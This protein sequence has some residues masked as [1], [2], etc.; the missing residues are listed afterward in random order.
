MVVY[1]PELT[2]NDP[3]APQPDQIQVGLK[4]HQR[5]ALAKAMAMERDGMIRYNMRHDD[6]QIDNH[7]RF[8]P[9]RGEVDIATNV[10]I[11]G[12]I[13]G[14]GKTLTALGIIASTPSQDIFQQ[15]TKTLSC[16]G[17]NIAH[18]T[19]SYRRPE[20]NPAD[21]FI[22]TTLV[23]VP[24]GPVYVQW[25][26]TIRT[27]TTLRVLALDSLP[28]I[29]KYC[30]G[31]ATEIADLKAFFEQ[32]DVVLLTNTSIK[33][34]MTFYE[35]PYHE[36]PIVAWDRI[37]IDEAH[38]LLHKMPLYNFRFLWLITGTYQVLS[39]CVYGARNSM[40]FVLRELLLEDRIPFLLLK[41]NAEF[42][43]KSFVVPP[44][45]EEYYL[46]EVP[47]HVS[48]IQ[49]F[50]PAHILD[51]VNANDI[52]GAIRELGG[53][54]ETEEDIVVLVTRDLQRD[55][56]NKRREIEY[57]ESLDMSADVRETRLTN[58]RTE[59]GRLEDRMK[60]LSERVTELSE[61]TCGICYDKYE[62]P[63]MLPC[64]HIFCGGCIMNWLRINNSVDARNKV[65]PQCRV[66]ITC[67]QLIA[68]VDQKVVPKPLIPAKPFVQSKEDTVMSILQN[69]PN[70]KFLIFSRFEGGIFWRLNSTLTRAGIPY[71]EIKGTT[72]QMMNIIDRFRNGDLRVIL[73]NTH[74]A[75]SGIDI[76]CATDVIIL[77]AME[78][79][80]VQA[81]GRA[82][83]VGRTSPL[84]IH[85][86]CYPHEMHT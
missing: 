65:C 83:R 58:L 56:N 70:G 6:I 51:R 69:K 15:T 20:M 4:P 34:F 62:N 82:Q 67:K 31:S 50:L 59:L 36:H 68:I 54:S 23:V 39:T 79:D 40:P 8:T 48:I 3:I 13:V 45:V 53:T 77:H 71:A 38:V 49:P 63:I 44:F 33:T 9:I 5:A 41:G 72:Y 73:L 74:Y 76:S 75:G 32:Y 11:L 12:D 16:V 47:H 21:R 61:K 17:R 29:R 46:C 86:L 28:K 1:G 7:Y 80:K 2:E 55:I 66:P 81:V 42:V 22:H 30:P 52:A 26:Q 19:A 18:F 84:M 64:T 24:R 10:G 57:V 25:E 14:Y 43:T 35:R 37:M 85:N 78:Y 27:Q 60:S